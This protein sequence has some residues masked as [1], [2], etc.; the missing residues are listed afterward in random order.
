[1]ALIPVVYQSIKIGSIVEWSPNKDSK[2]W[3]K[4]TITNTTKCES[5]STSTNMCDVIHELCPT[6]GL[7]LDITMSSTGHIRYE[8]CCSYSDTRGT[9]INLRG[10]NIKLIGNVQS[11]FVWD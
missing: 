7:L 4:A 2:L 1:M 10:T 11:E 8:K 5:F 6:N 9:N 3:I